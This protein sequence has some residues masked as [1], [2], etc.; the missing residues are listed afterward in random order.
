[1]TRQQRR[2]MRHKKEQKRKI[3]EADKALQLAKKEVKEAGSRYGFG[4]KAHKH[5]KAKE[6]RAYTN[7]FTA[8]HKQYGTEEERAA[9]PA[10]KMIAR[11][12]KEYMTEKDV[13]LGT[14]GFAEARKEN[15]PAI[16]K[17]K[18][19]GGS[20][21]KNYAYGGRVAKYSMEKS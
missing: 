6:K 12:Q 8:K 2:M 10:G 9:T 13:D 21:K 14:S 15:F 5:A 17:K 19:S 7:Y 16:P 1:M 18:A 20:V 11:Q 3:K 4:S